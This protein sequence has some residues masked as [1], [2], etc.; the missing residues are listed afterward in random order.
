[1]VE[2]GTNGRAYCGA[3]TVTWIDDCVH[4]GDKSS[5][6]F[7]QSSLPYSSCRCF[8]LLG[9]LLFFLGNETFRFTIDNYYRLL[10]NLFVSA[11]CWPCPTKTWANA[12]GREQPKKCEGKNWDSTHELR[13]N[14][15]VCH[16]L[17]RFFFKSWFTINPNVIFKSEFKVS[18]RVQGIR[19]VRLV[20]SQIWPI[21]ISTNMARPLTPW[22]IRE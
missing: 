18:C 16:G 15:V 13:G 17:R 10:G 19:W 7:S 12:G 21:Q 20:D 4:A 22:T 5:S 3:R 11:E 6:L 9:T 2:Q 14:S 1:M 8:L